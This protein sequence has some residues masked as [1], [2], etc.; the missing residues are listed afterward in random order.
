[1]V[2]SFVE[3]DGNFLSC[4]IFTH[5]QGASRWD[6]ETRRGAACRG[7]TGNNS[8]RTVT[9]LLVTFLATSS[10]SIASFVFH[11]LLVCYDSWPLF[12]NSGDKHL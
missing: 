10:I 9:I 2:V 1:M 4:V 7:N 12:S 6:T 3:F 11:C 8:S 5:R